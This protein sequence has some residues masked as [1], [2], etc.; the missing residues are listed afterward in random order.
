VSTVTNSAPP[1][2]GSGA[3]EG[4]PRTKPNPVTGARPSSE[5]ARDLFTE[6]TRTILVFVDGA[7]IQL[8]AAVAIGQLLFLSNKENNLEVL[9]QIVNKRTFGP[10]LC[11][12]ELQ[13]TEERANFWG[14]AFS[15]AGWKSSEFTTAE[16]VAAEQTTAADPGARVTTRSEEEVG[17]LKAQLEMLRQQV[18]AL[19]RKKAAEARPAT[20]AKEELMAAAVAASGGGER[21]LMPSAPAVKKVRGWTV[22][23]ALPTQPAEFERDPSEELLPEPALD[24]SQAPSTEQAQ[25]SG[26]AY[27]V[28]RLRPDQARRIALVGLLVVALGVGAYLKVWTVVPLAKNGVMGMLHRAPSSAPGSAS[29]VAAAAKVAG[30]STAAPSA[31]GKST[32]TAATPGVNPSVNGETLPTPAGNAK[33]SSN[34]ANALPA[35]TEK[36]LARTAPGVVLARRAPARETGSGRSQGGES[37]NVTEAKHAEVL[38]ADA[39]VIPAKLLHAAPPVYPPDAMWNF[40]T[41]DVRAEVVVDVSGKVG[42]VKV[43]SGPKALRDAAVE[44]LKKYEYAPATQGGKAIVSKAT[45]MVKFWFNP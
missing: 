43:L 27:W 6:E 25:A 16:H 37:P 32:G 24:F 5:G 30:K 14:V 11:Y 23:M 9:C 17:Q 31:S 28:K 13:F 1:L 26:P 7:V 35:K 21:L 39:P 22:P 3:S 42:E 12:V 15:N 18:Q 4:K 20:Q 10:S 38:A 36:E 19:E 33:G 44:A 2:T 8:S 40:I 45:A 34:G 29:S 41:G